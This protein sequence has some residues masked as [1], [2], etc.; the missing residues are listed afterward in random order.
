VGANY[1]QYAAFLARH[2]KACVAFEPN[3]ELARRIEETCGASGVRVHACALS[4]KDQDATLSIPVVDGVERS[5]LAT[6]ESENR[7]GD[8]PTRTVAVRCRRLDDFGLEPVGVIK[9][10][11]EGH[12]LA[13][14][15]GAEALIER[16]RPSFLIEAEE[17]HKPGSVKA[18]RDFLERRGYRA[19]MLVR[20]RLRPIE[21][22][23][24]AR[25]QDSASVRLDAIIEDR[26][27]VNNFVF[28]CEP[29][30]IDR[31]SALATR[32]HSL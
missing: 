5:A 21:E 4:D 20:R 22:F 19:F 6:I 27:Y 1:G 10:D 13:V 23:N 24:L 3:P 18:I 2:S 29:V 12:E 31:L 7:V 30:L 16:D 25:H 17:R 11:A 15:H 32:G 28:V 8:L 14:L 9:I 26:T